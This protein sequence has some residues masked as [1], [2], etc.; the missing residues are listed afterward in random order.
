MIPFVCRI[1]E[2]CVN[3]CDLINDSNSPTFSGPGET[4]CVCVASSKNHLAPYNSFSTN[5]HL[6]PDFHSPT[7]P[8]IYNEVALLQR[9]YRLLRQKLDFPAEDIILDC[10]LQTLRHDEHPSEVL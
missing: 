9:S 5:Q 8:A 3:N 7:W 6:Q 2:I 10:H 1:V 4:S